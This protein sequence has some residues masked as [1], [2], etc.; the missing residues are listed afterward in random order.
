MWR[1]SD[2]IPVEVRDAG[3]SFCLGNHPLQDAGVLPTSGD[4][5]TVIVQEGNVG[6]VTAMATVFLTW[7]LDN[8]AKQDKK[9]VKE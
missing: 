1:G 9:K 6:H 7:S 2:R 4:Q 8:K 5:V 3:V